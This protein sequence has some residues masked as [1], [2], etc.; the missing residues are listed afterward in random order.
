MSDEMK[1][2]LVELRDVIVKEHPY[3]VEATITFMQGGKVEVDI[4]EKEFMNHEC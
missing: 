1:K 3:T 2:A 4:Q